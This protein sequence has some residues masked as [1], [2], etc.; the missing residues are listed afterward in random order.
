MLP[1]LHTGFSGGR[2]SGLVF[3]SL[4]EISTVYCDPHSPYLALLRKA[5]YLSLLSI[6]V[7]ILKTALLLALLFILAVQ[8]GVWDLSSLTRN[9]THA[10]CSGSAESQQLGHR[11]SPW[12]WFLLVKLFCSHRPI[13]S[14]H[15]GG[16]SGRRLVNVRRM[17]KWRYLL[18]WRNM[19]SYKVSVYCL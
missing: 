14:E 3:L 18:P 16:T 11:G 10:L 5:V 12:L 8:P 2:S 15:E 9:W 4:S 13:S 17:N 6:V 1:D 7:F 19:H